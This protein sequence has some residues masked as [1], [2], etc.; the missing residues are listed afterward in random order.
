MKDK[1]FVA[2]T[3]TA[4][5]MSS[6]RPKNIPYQPLLMKPVFKLKDSFK[7]NFAHFRVIL[8]IFETKMSDKLLNVNFL[9]SDFDR[10]STPSAYSIELL[11]TVFKFREV[12]QIT[13]RIGFWNRIKN[14][15]KSCHLEKYGSTLKHTKKHPSRQEKTSISHKFQRHY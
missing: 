10:W 5:N 13:A 1:T 2:G 14:N 9:K 4:K 15:Y 7:V 12:F 3:E 8:N 6:I 11:V